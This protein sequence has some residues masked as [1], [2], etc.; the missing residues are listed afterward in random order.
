MLK[1]RQLRGSINER[2]ISTAPSIRE[3]ITP[4][5][6]LPQRSRRMP[7]NDRIAALERVPIM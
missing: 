7:L 2:R 1:P 3:T 6:R 4:Y 5:F